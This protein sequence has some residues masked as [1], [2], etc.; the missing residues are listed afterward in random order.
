MRDHHQGEWIVSCS[1]FC[2]VSFLGV[3]LPEAYQELEAGVGRRRRAKGE[4]LRQRFFCFHGCPT[5]WLPLEAHKLGT[6]PLP[7]GSG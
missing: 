3:V 4:L 7:S 1:A 5:P 6:C 2:L